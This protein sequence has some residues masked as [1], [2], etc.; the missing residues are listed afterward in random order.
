MRIRIAHLFY[1]V[2]LTTSTLAPSARVAYSSAALGTIERSTLTP[3]V[4]ELSLPINVPVLVLAYYPP[5]PNN[6]T[7]LDPVE[8][9]IFNFLIS[10]MQTYVQELVDNGQSFISDAT[11]YHGYKNS[12][13]PKYLS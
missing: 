11:R 13:A 6:P 4:N 5:D 10:D 8:T 12:S 7:Y 1:I 9:D 2:V 3:L